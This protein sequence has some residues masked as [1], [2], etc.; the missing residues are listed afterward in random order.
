MNHCT[1]TDIQRID[2]AEGIDDSIDEHVLTCDQCQA[3]LAELWDGQLEND[4]TEPVMRVVGLEEFVIAVI[5]EG[6]GILARIGEA[7]RVYGMGEEGK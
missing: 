6:G 7:L 3:F 2:F 1:I 5:K 4:L